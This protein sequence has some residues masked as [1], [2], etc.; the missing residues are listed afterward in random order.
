M[1]NYKPYSYLYKHNSD[2]S[3]LKSCFIVQIPAGKKITVQSGDPTTNGNT[4]FI[5]YS[6]EDD[7]ST[8][9]RKEEHEHVFN[10]NGKTHEVQ[11]II[12]SGSGDGGGTGVSSSDNGE[13][14]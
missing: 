5:R 2:P 1:N 9:I 12:G 8:S 14:Y 3:T 10:W 4:T 13:I 11:V 7:P 6:I